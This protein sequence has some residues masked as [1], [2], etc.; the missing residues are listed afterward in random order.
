MSSGPEA[1]AIADILRR[2][3]HLEALSQIVYDT[4][5]YSPT[6][7]GATTPGTTTYS[8]QV[9]AYA[10]LGKLVIA[11]FTMVWTAATGTGIALFGLPIAPSSTANLFQSGAAR[12][13]SITFANSTPG[14]NIT[15]G[16]A[17]FKLLSPITNAAGANVNMEAAGNIAGT[18]AYLID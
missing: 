12:I 10:Q 3:D 9:G 15:P 14:V 6:Y 4:S 18:I 2:L 11:A 1:R 5:T 7:L 17:S 13:E 16:I 8:I